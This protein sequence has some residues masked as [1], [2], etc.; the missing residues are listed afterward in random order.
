MSSIFDKIDNQSIIDRI[1][2]L[3]PDSKPLW[4]KMSVDQML[5]HA[6]ET[7]IVAFGEKDIKVNFISR[8]LGKMSKKNIFNFGF[9]KNSPTAKEFIFTAK[10][11]FDQVKTELIKNFGRFTEKPV[12]IT[13]MDHPF[14]G[15]MTY[16]D[17]NKLMWK[18]ID[19]H[20]KQFGV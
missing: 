15:R 9:K 13:V 5:K 3:E 20:L 7:I 1:S 2:I 17:W 18:H 12:P 8:L 10:Y 14:W 16:K 11:D 6:N 19:H 4:G